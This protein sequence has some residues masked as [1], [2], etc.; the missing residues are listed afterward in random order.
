MKK[1]INLNIISSSHEPHERVYVVLQIII[2]LSSTTLLYPAIKR[3]MLFR[4]AAV[5]INGNFHC[6]K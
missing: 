1:A 4:N 2:L 6:N 5:A 3:N